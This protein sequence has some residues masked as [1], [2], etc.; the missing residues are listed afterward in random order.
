M[1]DTIQLKNYRCFEN[2]KIKFRDLSVIVGKNNAG[3]STLLEALRLVAMAVRKCTYTTY[4]ELPK[5]LGVPARDKG[6]RLEAEKLKIDLRGI[7]Y[8]YES[9]IAQ[10]IVQLDSG[11][12]IHIYANR[13]YAYAV[14][15]DMEKRNIKNKNRAAEF[16][17][18]EI[19][20]LPQISLI[21]ES[22]KRLN[23]ETIDGERETYLASRHFR[24]EIYSDKDKYW[25]EFKNLA[26]QTWEG[27]KIKNIEY[28]AFKDTYISLYVSDN[29]FPAEIGLM[30]SGL[31]MWLQIM[32]FLCR[33][34]GYETVILDEPDVYMHPDLQ[35]KLIR[36]VKTRYPQAI[37]ATHSVEMISEVDASNILMIDKKKKIMSYATDLKAVQKIVDEI[38]AVNNLSLTRIGN[39]RKC[40]FVEGEDLKILSKIADSIGMSGNDSIAS[41]PHVS[42]RGFNNLNEAFGTAQLFYDETKGL[43][44]CFCILDRDYFPEELLNEKVKCAIENHLE[45]HIW[46][47]K[48]IENYLLEPELLFAVTGRKQS[49]YKV[50]LDKLDQLADLFYNEVFDQYA[51]H[52]LKYNRALDHSTANKM[53]REFLKEKWTTLEHKLM[54]IEG[55]N[56]IKTYNQWVKREYG[57]KSCS[58]NLLIKMCKKEYLNSEFTEVLERLV[59]CAK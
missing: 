45:L 55:K 40:I 28:N 54:L 44:Q 46:K 25:D 32:W 3:K 9:N 6:F 52:I 20:I 26:E 58:L 8:L 30:G 59:E 2:S 27:L 12:K 24:N 37:I 10:V 49:E 50:F 19:G 33:T 18:K 57:I 7:V 1:I 43:I 15:Y 42:L 11:V 31:Q 5:D 21:K 16:G 14:L 17:L 47:R 56:F 23:A 48:E 38:G 13:S 29:N 22:E 41:L 36:I 53:A 51:E 35:R 39:Y 34:K 4:K